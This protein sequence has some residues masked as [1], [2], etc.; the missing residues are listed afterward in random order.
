[1]S[2]VIDL[3]HRIAP[4]MPVYP[5]TEPPVLEQANT[6]E[7]NGFAETLLRM[8][9][10]TGTHIDAP[11]HMVS[12]APF[13]DQLPVDRFVGPRLRRRRVGR[14][15]RRIGAEALDAQR[16]LVAGC[17]FVL[18]HTGWSRYW[19]DDRYFAGVPGA[20]AAAAAWIIARGREGR[21]IRRDLRRTRSGRRRTRITSRSSRRD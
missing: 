8:Y 19:G 10:H 2:H 17:D 21:G 7:H 6:V 18:L 12:G 14:E 1:M 11:G 5:G 15:G 3:T 4:R 9:S 20:V 13:L 16:D